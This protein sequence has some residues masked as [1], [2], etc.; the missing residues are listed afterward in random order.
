[1]DRLSRSV[2]NEFTSH[3]KVEL[4][5]EQNECSNLG[6][7]SLKVPEGGWGQ[8]ETLNPNSQNSYCYWK[9]LEGKRESTNGCIIHWPLWYAIM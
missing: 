7:S 3:T 2:R 8:V 9:L 5:K 6:D 4:F 1:M